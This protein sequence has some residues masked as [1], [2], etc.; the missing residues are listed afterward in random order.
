MHS[1]QNRIVLD[2]LELSQGLDMAADHVTIMSLE[3]PPLLT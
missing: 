1:L 2:V 3:I